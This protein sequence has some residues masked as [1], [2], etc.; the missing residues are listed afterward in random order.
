M[1][2]YTEKNYRGT[3]FI[4]I[5]LDKQVL[6]SS[7]SK[8]PWGSFHFSTK[9]LRLSII[10][11]QIFKI[12][13]FEKASWKRTL[14]LISFF[15]SILLFPFFRFSFVLFLFALLFSLHH[16]TYLLLTLHFVA[17]I[18]CISSQGS[19]YFIHLMVSLS[20]LNKL[21]KNEDTPNF[22]STTGS[23]S[24]KT[25][26]MVVYKGISNSRTTFE[27]QVQTCKLHTN[28]VS[29]SWTNGVCFWWCLGNLSVMLFPWPEMSS[30]RH[31][32]QLDIWAG[33][34]KDIFLQAICL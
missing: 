29:P 16:V 11:A 34:T 4:A 1:V 23:S 26:R 21:A 8:E 7:P 10:S 30:W 31:D 17:N 27:L 28:L 12:K 9:V 2:Q 15:P 3:R 5:I 6:F 14:F 25:F 13:N 22:M 19:P 18:L 32:W 20:F 24:C 33:P